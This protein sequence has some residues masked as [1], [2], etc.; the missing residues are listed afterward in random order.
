M[1]AGNFPEGFTQAILAVIIL[2]GRLG[3]GGRGVTA[4][5][6]LGILLDL[7]VFFVFLQELHTKHGVS[8]SGI[9][10]RVGILLDR[11]LKLRRRD[12]GGFPRVRSAD[13]GAARFRM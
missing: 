10:K 5:R 8:S 9:T 4:S 3:A 6:S 11:S 2:V 12:A 1:P 13:P 7:F